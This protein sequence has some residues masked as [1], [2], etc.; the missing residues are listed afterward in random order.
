MEEDSVI[1]AYTSVLQLDATEARPSCQEPLQA[2]TLDAVYAEEALVMS[3][4]VALPLAASSL[5]AAVAAV[6]GLWLSVVLR[7]GKGIPSEGRLL[8]G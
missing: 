5:A 4:S 1:I 3:S 7:S 6:E 8:R 2:Y